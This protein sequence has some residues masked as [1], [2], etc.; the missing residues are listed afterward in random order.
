PA[1][2]ARERLDD[3]RREAAAL[4]ADAVGPVAAH[5]AARPYRLHERQ[6]ILRHD[7]ET[8]EEGLTAH[9]AELVDGREGADRGAVADL[10]VSC[11]RGVVGEDGLASDAAVM[12]DVGARHEE[13]V[14]AHPRQA[15]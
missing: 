9:A 8:P 5:V 4:E 14:V 11:E 12:R 15:A 10:D 2:R 13:V 3:G 7:R 6:G 1:E